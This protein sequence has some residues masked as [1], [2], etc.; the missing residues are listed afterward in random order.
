MAVQV[1]RTSCRDV[2]ELAS[3]YGLDRGMAD[4]LQI[5]ERGI[6]HPGA[7]YIKALG[8]LVQR[9]D[10]FIAMAGLFSQQPQYEE[11]QIGRSQFSP[12]AERPPAPVAAARESLAKVAEPAATLM[13]SQKIMDVMM[14]ASLDL[15]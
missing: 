10:D 14:H 4:F 12:H 9:L 1:L 13:P 8:P 6:H 2:V 3:A 5:R 7:R 15:S 11:L